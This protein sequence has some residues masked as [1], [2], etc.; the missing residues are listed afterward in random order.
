MHQTLLYAL[1]SVRNDA[2]SVVI[3]NIISQSNCV[4]NDHISSIHEARSEVSLS[5]K[6][7]F[8]SPFVP[9]FPK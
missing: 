3:G 6:F 2:I 1:I 9:L 5:H 7:T 4:I 8:E